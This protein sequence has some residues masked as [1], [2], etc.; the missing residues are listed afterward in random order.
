[1]CVCVQS[2]NMFS[3][4]SRRSNQSSP[5]NPSNSRAREGLL[6]AGAAVSQQRLL[7]EEAGS[8]PRAR[9]G[10]LAWVTALALGSENTF[11]ALASSA[12]RG[13]FPPPRSP[14]PILSSWPSPHPLLPPLSCCKTKTPHSRVPELQPNGRSM[15]WDAGL[16]GP[17]RA[18][19]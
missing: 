5:R 7:R 8:C 2:T 17:E 9:P 14:S 15:G 4:S 6:P 13:F 19:V 11:L 10:C 3:P 16:P 1:M 18:K 12:A